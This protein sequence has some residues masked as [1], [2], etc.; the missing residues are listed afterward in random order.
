[1]IYLHVVVDRGGS[2]VFSREGGGV[3]CWIFKSFQNFSR[4]F[5]VDRPNRFSELSQSTIKTLFW[6][7]LMETQA[8]F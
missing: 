6:P 8:K 3:V 4:V 5:F 1:M 2:T 7:N